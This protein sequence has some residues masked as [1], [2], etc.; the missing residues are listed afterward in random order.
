MINDRVLPL[1][2]EQDLQLLR[3]LTDRETEFCGQREHHEYQL[4]LVIEY[5]DHKKTE[6]K[7]PQTNKICERFQKTF[8]E[9]LYAIAYRKKIYTSIEEIQANLDN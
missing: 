7:S 5:I 9:E 2:E 6:T 3:I 8:E 4:Y 1:Y